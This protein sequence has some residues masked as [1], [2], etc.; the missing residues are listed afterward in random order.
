MAALGACGGSDEVQTVTVE[1]T[2]RE[3]SPPA[4]EDGPT[5]AEAKRIAREAS[6][7]LSDLPNGWQQQDDDGEDD[8]GSDYDDCP[9]VGQAR[10]AVLARYGSP[11][12][13]DDADQQVKNFVYIYGS[14]REAERWYSGITSD[15]TRACLKRVIVEVASDFED[16]DTGAKVEDVASSRVST[17]P[18]GDEA[19]T[20][21]FN[22]SI[23]SDIIDTEYIIDFALVRS[24]RG[25]AIFDLRNSDAPFEDEV[26][27][28]AMV[29]VVQRLRDG[30]R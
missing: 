11:T 4:A 21:R 17:E 23:T 30:L 25:V 10:E 8:D 20:A 6:L 3:Q 9:I 12:F 19:T 18:L 5:S 27:S 29:S 28:D 13:S 16:E 15:E 14:E 22:L 24:G 26:R 1:S 7:R 2:E